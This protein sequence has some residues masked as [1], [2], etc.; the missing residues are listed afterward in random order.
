MASCVDHNSAIHFNAMSSTWFCI[1]FGWEIEVRWNGYACWITAALVKTACRLTCL[2]K[3]AAQLCHCWCIQWHRISCWTVLTKMSTSR[4]SS[5]SPLGRVPITH[6]TWSRQSSTDV[7][8]ESLDHQSANERWL[9]SP[10]RCFCKYKCVLCTFWCL[11]L[12]ISSGHDIIPLETRECKTS[13][14]SEWVHGFV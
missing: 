12:K 1:I 5:T 3:L 6:R 14:M 4:T 10:W 13:G 11:S 9:S 2:L 8:R 7:A